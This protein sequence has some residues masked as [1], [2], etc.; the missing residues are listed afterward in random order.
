MRYRPGSKKRLEPALD[1][2]YRKLGYGD[3]RFR[4][5][6]AQAAGELLAVPVP[7]GAVQVVPSGPAFTFADP[8]LEA[9]N[10]ARKHLLRTGPDNIRKVQDRIRALAAALQLEI[11]SP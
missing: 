8:T 5:V 7:A 1:L 4:E 6:L 10:D 3:R 11:V 2:A 9:Q